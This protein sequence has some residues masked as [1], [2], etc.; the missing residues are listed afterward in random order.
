MP[1][2]YGCKFGDFAAPRIGPGIEQDRPFPEHQSRILDEDR[3]RKR[4]QRV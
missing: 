1:V 2:E 4:L 3:I